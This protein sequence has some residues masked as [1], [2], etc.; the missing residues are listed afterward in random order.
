M[1]HTIA[2]LGSFGAA[3]IAA[4]FRKPR[5]ILGY[6]IGKKMDRL[7][8]AACQWTIDFLEPR[9]SDTVL[10]IGFGTGSGL[11]MLSDRVREGRILGIDI[12]PYKDSMFDCVFAVNV[13]YFWDEPLLILKEIQRVLQSG[14]RVAFF[15]LKRET[16]WQEVLTTGIMTS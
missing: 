11:M 9:A 7:N 16:F 13:M 1:H 14:G 6:L 8:R 12:S 4:Q 5:G 2:K 15:L 10:E 3:I